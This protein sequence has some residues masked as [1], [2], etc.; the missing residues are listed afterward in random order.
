MTTT[1]KAI[2]PESWPLQAK[3]LD[4]IM[5]KLGAMLAMEVGPGKAQVRRHRRMH[6]ERRR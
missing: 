4:F 5:D 3:G 6:G 2:R 1:T